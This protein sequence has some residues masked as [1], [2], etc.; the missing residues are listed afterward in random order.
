MVENLMPENQTKRTKPVLK[1]AGGKSGLLP[2][3]LP[4]FPQKIERYFEPFFGGGAVFF[5][6]EFS[7]ESFLNDINSE[8]IELY[9]AVRDNR[10]ELIAELNLLSAQYSEEFYYQMRA[11]IPQ[12]KTKRAARTVFLN[13]TGFNGLYRQNSKGGFNVPFGKRVKC[14]ALFDENNLIKVSEVLGAAKLM[15]VDFETLINQA[16]HGDFVYCDPPYEPLSATSSFNAYQGGGFSRDEQKRLKNACVRAQARGANVIIS[17]S[18]AE[19]IKDLYADCEIKSIS[20][21][22]AINS[23]GNSRGEIEELAII[24]GGI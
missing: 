19:F 20:A 7:S 18:A 1:W 23:K 6:L 10:I 22:R 9:E 24:L 8:L 15:S 11:L 14:P 4:L 16:G 13:K 21:R 5:A 17:N 3:L 2:Q 12:T